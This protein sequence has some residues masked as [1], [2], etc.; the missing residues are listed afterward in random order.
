VNPWLRELAHILAAV[1]VEDMA[2]SQHRTAVS[3]DGAVNGAGGER[4]DGAEL[5]S[6]S[7]TASE[8]G[9]TEP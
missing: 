3:A 7:R 8:A 9:S 5:E 2:N 1:A 6:G 4:K